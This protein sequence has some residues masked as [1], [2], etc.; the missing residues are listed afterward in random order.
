M[1]S[2]RHVGS[3]YVTIA[4]ATFVLLVLL[5]LNTAFAG[6]PIAI[7]AVRETESVSSTEDA[8]DDPAIWVHPS[9]AA[10]S[11]VIGTDK[12]RGLAVYD[13]QGKQVSF[14]PDGEMNNVDVRNGFPLGGADITLVAA[15]NRVDNS[16]AVYALDGEAGTLKNVAANPL[17]TDIEV[18]GFCLYRENTGGEFYAFVNSK[19]GEVQQWRLF[20]NG[21]GKIDM[22]KVVEFHV[23][24]QVE[25]MV[26]DDARNQLYIGEE[27]VAVWRYPLPID[28]EEFI[29]HPVDVTGPLGHVIEDVEGLTLYLTPDDGGYLIASNQGNDE[30]LVYERSEPNRFLGSFRIESYDGIDNVSGTDGIDVTSAVLPPPYDR[31]LLVVQDDEDDHGN[32]NF[33]YIPWSSVVEALTLK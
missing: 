26:A 15:S 2:M 22:E 17:R 31:G 24:S 12:Q 14:A 23:G 8:A 27:R 13:L 25:G 33:K 3:R 1:T 28:A 32:Q 19:L 6:E 18:Y 4:A 9:D 11:L 20:D 30:F 29:R 16:I 10:K 5:A 21:D 7:H